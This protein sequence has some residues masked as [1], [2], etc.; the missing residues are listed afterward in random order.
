MP[1]QTQATWKNDVQ[2]GS[3]ASIAAVSLAR[4]WR[5]YI[6]S[7]YKDNKKGS[8]DVWTNLFDPYTHQKWFG[9]QEITVD[10]KSKAW[11]VM[12]PA[13]GYLNLNTFLIVS[14]GSSLGYYTIPYPADADSP[15]DFK[16]A[17]VAVFSPIAITDADTA[18]RPA[19]VNFGDQLMLL[20]R[21]SSGHVNMAT[22][23]TAAGS[24]LNWQKPVATTFTSITHGPSVTVLNNNLFCAV[25]QN[26]VIYVGKSAD[27]INWA[28]ILEIQGASSVLGPAIS[29]DPTGTKSI[30]LW[31]ATDETLHTIESTDG[32]VW[33]N[34][35]AFPGQ[36]QD[37][38]ALMGSAAGI[39]LAVY[40]AS[41]NDSLFYSNTESDVFNV[42][43]LAPPATSNQGTSAT[44]TTTNLPSR[45]N[46]NQKLLPGGQLASPDG[47]Y[48]F[49]FQTDGN[50][51]L[52][53]GGTP[54]WAANT[55]ATDLDYLIMQD[56]GNLVL[57][58]KQQKAK[59]ATKT[60][61]HKGAYL[62]VQDD[63]N[64]IV[65]SSDEKP[66]W[67]TKTDSA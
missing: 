20:Y 8:Q 39:M 47:N 52:Y 18:T 25:N 48:V 10:A 5:G 26:G 21:T 24:P 60:D 43:P 41:D 62:T 9:S 50:I 27:G 16:K 1:T 33:T 49:T 7:A 11:S 65:I 36:T 34:S 2:I 55:N 15:D 64:A 6:L 32:V 17:L 14:Q 23:S 29:V 53:N 46:A 35:Q 13:V 37:S 58:D 4:V 56:D 66:L 19:L 44:A 54:I 67:A 38:P 28:P 59:W 12:P 40:R 51:V 3:D 57:Y 42:L 22:A 63:G 30:V 31:A 45:L 61:K